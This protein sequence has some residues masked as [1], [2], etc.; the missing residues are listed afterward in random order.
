MDIGPANK[1]VDTDEMG[2]LNGFTFPVYQFLKLAVTNYYE[3][4][5]FTE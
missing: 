1:I 2:L 4:V 3:L 5:N